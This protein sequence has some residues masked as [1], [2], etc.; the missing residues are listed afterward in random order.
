MHIDLLSLRSLAA[1]YS[2][3]TRWSGLDVLAPRPTFHCY[4]EVNS[5]TWKSAVKFAN[6]VKEIGK[7]HKQEML[8]HEI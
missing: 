5:N 3:Y 1:N 8:K 7:T 6:V 4:T 2:S